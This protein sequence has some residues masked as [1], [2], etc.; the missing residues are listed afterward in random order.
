MEQA[1]SC[2]HQ[3][4]G[5]RMAGGCL[6]FNRGNFSE[7]VRKVI[8]LEYVDVKTEYSAQSILEEMSTDAKRK[9]AYNI[10]M[11][12]SVSDHEM[13]TTGAIAV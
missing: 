6:N 7:N 12:D 1:R 13:V 10:R 11:N 4:W 3:V 8:F 5:E 9:E 2:P